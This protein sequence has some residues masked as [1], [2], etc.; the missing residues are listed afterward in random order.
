[1]ESIKVGGFEVCAKGIWYLKPVQGQQ[2]LERIEPT[3]VLCLRKMW[4]KAFPAA[5]RGERRFGPRK[6]LRING[7][8][9]ISAFETE[10][11]EGGEPS[12]TS[13]LARLFR[14]AEKQGS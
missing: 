14:Q 4:R 8:R 10:F 13:F 5:G 9:C 6:A 1:M 11:L 12:T 7:F 2:L 3:S